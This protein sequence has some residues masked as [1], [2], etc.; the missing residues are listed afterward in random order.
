MT[1]LTIANALVTVRL[2]LNIP[3]AKVAS[4]VGDA[5]VAGDYER[6]LQ[7]VEDWARDFYPDCLEYAGEPEVECDA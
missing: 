7:A 6:E 3:E 4:I 1:E 5:G 2:S